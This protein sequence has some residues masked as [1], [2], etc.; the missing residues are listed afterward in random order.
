MF[1][2]KKKDRNLSSLFLVGLFLYV[3]LASI[4]NIKKGVMLTAF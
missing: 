1:R 4:N 2:S 3:C